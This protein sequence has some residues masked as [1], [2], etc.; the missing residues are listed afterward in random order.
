MVGKP[1]PRRT[2]IVCAFV[3]LTPGHSPSRE[4][5]R[6]LQDFAKTVTVP[7]KYPREIRYVTELPKTVSGK[8]R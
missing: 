4:L 8:I 3:I 1:D 2:E 6:E 7:Y 5:T